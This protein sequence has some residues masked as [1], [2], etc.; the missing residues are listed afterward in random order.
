MFQLRSKGKLKKTR[1][2]LK[3]CKSLDFQGIL[4]KYAEIGVESLRAAT[5][6]DSGETR[7]SWGYEIEYG[8]DYVSIHWTN[9]NVNKTA[10]IALLLQYGHATGTGGWVEGINYIN[11]ALKPVFDGILNELWKEVIG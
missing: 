8:T 2:F 5:P 10:V 11:P 4:E 1:K 6:K 7:D 3:R 9:S